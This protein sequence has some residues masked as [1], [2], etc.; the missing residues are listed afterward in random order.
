MNVPASPTQA[1]PRAW[2]FRNA[3]LRGCSWCGRRTK[4]R[5]ANP[6]PLRPRTPPGLWRLTAAA[7]RCPVPCPPMWANRSYTGRPRLAGRSIL[8]GPA[9]LWIIARPSPPTPCEPIPNAKSP[10]GA[11]AIRLRWLSARRQILNARADRAGSGSARPSASCPCRL[12]G[13]MAPGRRSKP[14]TRGLSNRHWDHRYGRPDP[15]H[16]SRSDTAL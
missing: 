10:D 3:F 15:W 11:G 7:S 2:V 9:F 13:A 6:C 1:A 8:G 12:L 4:L 5:P 16:R 14:T